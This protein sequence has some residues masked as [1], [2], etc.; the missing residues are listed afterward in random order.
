MPTF[1]VNPNCADQSATI[2]K[3]SLASILAAIGTTRTAVVHLRH[4]SSGTTTLYK[5]TTA[6]DFTAYSNV[7]FTFNPGAVLQVAN[8]LTI[9]IPRMDDTLLGQR[10]D[11]VGTAKVLLASGGVT[12]S[13]P[14]WWGA[15]PYATATVNSAALQRWLDSVG[16]YPTIPLYLPGASSG[17]P[18]QVN[19]ALVKTS[20]D[21]LT[22]YGDGATSWLEWVGA[23]KATILK[24]TGLGSGRV[25]VCGVRFD[26]NSKASVG[27]SLAGFGYGL[28]V[29]RCEFMDGLSYSGTPV[30]DVYGMLDIPKNGETHGVHIYESGFFGGNSPGIS[31]GLTG[32]ASSSAAVVIEDNQGQQIDNW[33]AKTK[34]LKQGSKVSNNVVDQIY[35]NLNGG[36]VYCD[37]AAGVA[38]VGNAMES[39]HSGFI[40]VNP[41]G[42][43]DYKPMSAY[44]ACNSMIAGNSTD[45]AYVTLGHTDDVV[46]EGNIAA[47]INSPVGGWLSVLS[48]VDG[49]L[50]T[51]VC[52]NTVT[53]D[54]VG[55]LLWAEQFISGTGLWVVRLTQQNVASTV[56]LLS[57]SAQSSSSN[58]VSLSS[59]STTNTPNIPVDVRSYTLHVSITGATAGARIYLVNEGNAPAWANR[60][61][62]TRVQFLEL[63]V[64]GKTKT[65]VL[66]ISVKNQSYIDSIYYGIDMAGVNDTAVE[67]R[68]ISYQMPT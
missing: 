55:G 52:K 9:T 30:N 37:Y 16:T 38:I 57:L 43:Y 65:G 56:A 41:T 49:A 47:G 44:I 26:C 27:L 35:T 66:T 17:T 45:V 12:R 5:A 21:Y 11:C 1:I 67:L 61:T 10:F 6:V 32:V 20:A 3:R 48:G 23:D 7:T 54:M 18:Y 25:E 14:T 62:D 59:I 64:A 19:A 40:S 29:R 58:W 36:G 24:L 33:F 42:R 46:L 53:S 50:G 63:E 15:S 51:V 28:T 8:G 34:G 68:L 31:I 22:V 4:S 39:M 60:A 13:T 2:Y